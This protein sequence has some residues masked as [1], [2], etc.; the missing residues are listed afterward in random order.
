MGAKTKAMF[1]LK[2][3]MVNPHLFSL[4][5]IKRSLSPAIT[6]NP[7]ENTTTRVFSSGFRSSSMQYPYLSKKTRKRKLRDFLKTSFLFFFSSGLRS[8]RTAFREDKPR[9]YA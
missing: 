2:S 5:V 6:V 4:T 9:V 1:F 3:G 8:P 7:I